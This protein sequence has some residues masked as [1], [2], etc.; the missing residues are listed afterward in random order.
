MAFV[1]R[2]IGRGLNYQTKPMFAMSILNEVDGWLAENLD[3]IEGY[4]KLSCSGQVAHSQ[5][6]STDVRWL[7]DDR[8][9]RLRK[10][11]TKIAVNSL[12]SLVDTAIYFSHHTGTSR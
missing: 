6:S 7:Q 11:A 3:H 10:P 1:D 5:D 8:M 9:R 12:S 2:S 4:A